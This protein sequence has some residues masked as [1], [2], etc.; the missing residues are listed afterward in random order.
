MKAPLLSRLAGSELAS[1]VF[2]RDYLQLVFEPGDSRPPDPRVLRPATEG[3]FATLSA[4][5]VPT[6][7]RGG[8]TIGRGDPGWRD[9]LCDQI[10]RRVR[11][12]ARADNA[13]V[14][15]FDNNDVVRI[16]LASQDAVGPE[17]ALLQLEDPDE[18]DVW[19]PGE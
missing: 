3:R 6:V 1:V 8:R 10:G 12:A 5:T 7:S 11:S 17:F 15:E 19:R 4:F 13:L 2:V 18:W 9:G 14:V 16:S